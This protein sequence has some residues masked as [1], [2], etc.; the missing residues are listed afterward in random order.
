MIPP[1]GRP[2][3]IGTIEAS[4][5]ESRCIREVRHPRR[6]YCTAVDRSLGDAN[7]TLLLIDYMPYAADE[8]K[9]GR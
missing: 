6:A 7:F 8:R 9:P 4:G 5:N 1:L 3:S 2:G